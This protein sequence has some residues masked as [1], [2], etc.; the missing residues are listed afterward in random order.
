[1]ALETVIRETPARAAMSFNRTV[2]SDRL[3][4]TSSWRKPLQALR[5]PCWRRAVKHVPILECDWRQ[6]TMFDCIHDHVDVTNIRVAELHNQEESL[7]LPGQ[8]HLK[9]EV[10]TPRRGVRA[11]PSGPSPPSFAQASPPSHRC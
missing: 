1:M 6:I 7:G 2:M 5:Q 9:S 3:M 8:T 10:G 11:R 4:R